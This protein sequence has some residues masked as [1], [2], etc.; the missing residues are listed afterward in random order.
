MAATG[1]DDPMGW[2]AGI[3]L[4]D[5]RGILPRLPQPRKRASLPTP[6]IRASGSYRLRTA[7]LLK[8]NLH[9]KR[10]HRSLGLS[11]GS[12]D[13]AIR[14]KEDREHYACCNCVRRATGDPL[15][16]TECTMA[17]SFDRPPGRVTQCALPGPHGVLPDIEK[18]ESVV[19][20]FGRHI[21]SRDSARKSGG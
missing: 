16:C 4:P 9:R 10:Y 3:S 19:R 8:R 12:S 21:Y 18:K 5:T 1:S 20:F 13:L 7:A 2:P 15:G 11:Q 14:H 6:A 17:A